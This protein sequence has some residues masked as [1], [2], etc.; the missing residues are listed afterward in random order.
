VF[1]DETGTPFVPTEV[2][3]T[4]Y[5]VDTGNII[6]G[7]DTQDVKAANGGA[8]TGTNF[9]LELTPADLSLANPAR[10]RETHVLL[11]VSRWGS[12]RV[13]IT[14]VEHIVQNITRIP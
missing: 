10:G 9:A 12:G 3:A 8:F 4:L 1:R 11:L 7:R 5:D 6:N 13:N 14:E 2:E